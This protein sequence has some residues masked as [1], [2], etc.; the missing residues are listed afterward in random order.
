MLAIASTTSRKQEEN[1]MPNFGQKQPAG[2]A[3]APG[4][5]DSPKPHGDKLVDAVEGV[6]GD[7]HPS[8]ETAA[9]DSAPGAPDSPK[10]HGDK[11]PNAVRSTM[12]GGKL[13]R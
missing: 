3:E 12:G 4:S 13:D 10:P 5:P 1:E 2:S 8:Q 6:I 11:L 7:Q 9:S